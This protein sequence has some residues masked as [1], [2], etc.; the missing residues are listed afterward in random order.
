MPATHALAGVPT[1]AQMQAALAAGHSYQVAVHENAS[2]TT[3]DM[4]WIVVGSG[5]RARY[6]LNIATS[7]ANMVYVA[8]ATRV[9]FKVQG[10]PT[11]WTCGANS[12][13][14]F[15][16]YF[17]LLPANTLLSLGSSAKLVA[18]HAR[19]IAGQKSQGYAVTSTIGTYTY[20]GAI[21]LASGTNRPTEEDISY[22]LKGSRSPTLSFS[23]V[24]SHWN[25]PKLRTMSA[26]GL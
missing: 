5:N 9:C 19:T 12:G 26:P 21:Y 10:M 6:Q 16:G 11:G 13:S 22:G 25:D 14:S 23:I 1:V 7:G 17:D 4:T 24:I 3:V 8:N 15:S 20:S 2:G 18:T